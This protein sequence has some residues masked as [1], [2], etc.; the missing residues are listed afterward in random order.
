M[1]VQNPILKG[2][3]PDPTMCKAQDKYYIATSTFQWY[4]GITIY[5]SK[6]L[7]NW[8]IVSQPLVDNLGFDLRGID[9]SAGIWAP[10]LVYEN[11]K[12]YLSYTIVKSATGVYYD[13]ENYIIT[14][15]EIDGKWNIPK[16]INNGCFDPSLFFED[17]KLYLLAKIVD[18]RFEPSNDYID[19]YSGIIIQELNKDS[20]EQIGDFEILTHG[21][22]LG[23]EEG[24]Q[25]FKRNE[26]YYL[27]I[28]EGGTEYG[29]QT[30]VMRSEKLLGPYEV[31]PNNPVLKS[32]MDTYLQKAGHSSFVNCGDDKWIISHLCSRPIHSTAMNIKG[33]LCCPLGRET[34]IQ[35]VEWEDD[36]PCIVGGGSAPST[37]FIAI[38]NIEIK[39]KSNFEYIPNDFPGEDFLSLRREIVTFNRLE[40]GKLIMLGQDSLMSKFDVNMYAIRASSLRFTTSLTLSFSPLNYLQ[41][42]GLTL[43]YDTENYITIFISNDS[44]FGKCIKVE[45]IKHKKYSTLN[46]TPISVNSDELRL[47]LKVDKD[48]ITGFY[49]EEGKER[50]I[51]FEYHTSYLS[52]DYILLDKPSFFTGMMIGFY[53]CDLTGKE[54]KA[55]IANFDV[56][57]L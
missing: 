46:V 22:G 21:T 13:M 23:G 40:N 3:N 31:H 42:S 5:E 28:A 27:N 25:L 53:C 1:K 2:F 30:T 52:D 26:Y 51:D 10:N 20:L 43:Y 54:Q 18:H 38:D 44:K 34:A 50:K 55:T 29:H 48:A 19:K 49:I 17:E 8:N 16:Q 57:N 11:N 24:P 12:F 14:S 4:P 33:K 15:D 7:V 36:W 47:M 32:T 56:K 41:M 39:H 45:S 9:D 37:E 6:D 35:N